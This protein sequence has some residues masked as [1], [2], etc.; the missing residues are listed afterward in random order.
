MNPRV[1]LRALWV[2]A[3]HLPLCFVAG[4]EGEF[5]G[6]LFPIVQGQIQ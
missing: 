6:C 3:S 2:E 5:H 4:C 1:Y